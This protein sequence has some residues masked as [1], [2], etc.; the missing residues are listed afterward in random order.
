MGPTG[1]SISVVVVFRRL[2]AAIFSIVAAACA[3]E[4]FIRYANTDGMSTVDTFRCIPIAI[5]TWLLAGPGR[6]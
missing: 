3:A 4:L 1:G 6:N 5:P 2:A